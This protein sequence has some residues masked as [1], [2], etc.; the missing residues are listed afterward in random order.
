V[1]ARNVG[2]KGVILC[3]ECFYTGVNVQRTEKENKMHDEDKKKKVA[4]SV[5][6][7]G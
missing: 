2:Y 1:N 3:K 4:D 5:A 7:C 6:R